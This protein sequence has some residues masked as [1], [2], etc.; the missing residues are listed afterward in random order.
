[1][2][3]RL[4]QASN[5][6]MQAFKIRLHE[7]HRPRTRTRAD[8]RWASTSNMCRLY[9]RALQIDGLPQK[10]RMLADGSGA[11]ESEGRLVK[12][13]IPGP[14]WETILEHARPR[15]VA[16][17]GASGQIEKGHAVRKLPDG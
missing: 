7:G 17:L 5:G 12:L 16:V 2:I 8:A 10:K 3:K 13:H 15:P 14:V 6:D 4:K 9:A 11:M 1:M